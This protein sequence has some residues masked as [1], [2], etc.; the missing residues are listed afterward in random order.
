MKRAINK[1]LYLSD[2]EPLKSRALA[3]LG[4][5]SIALCAQAQQCS[6]VE[7]ATELRTIK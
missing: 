5:Q 2:A 4:E 3:F 1:K 6:S 7:K